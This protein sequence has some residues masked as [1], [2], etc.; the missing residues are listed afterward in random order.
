MRIGELSRRVGVS[1]DTLRV[2][3]RRYGLLRP[4]RSPGNA[5]LYSAVDEA[6]VRLMQRYINQRVPPA[7]AAQLSLAARF[8]LRGGR[9]AIP[10][11]DD[12]TL[13]SGQLRHA[14]D[15]FDEA[16][17]DQAL[18]RM[19]TEYSTPVVM[20]S[21]LLPYLH[22]VGERWAAGRTT[23]AQEHFASNFVMFRLAALSRGW[24]RGLGPRA[25]LACAP[26]EQ[27][28]IGLMCFG[29]ALHQH[30]WRI[31]FLGAA[32]PIDMLHAAAIE[33]RPDLITVCTYLSGGLAP[34][35]EEL[36]ELAAEWHLA[37]AGPGAGAG[38]AARCRAQHLRED[39]V[40]AA[41]AVAVGAFAPTAS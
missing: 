40:S 41:A 17:A 9:R 33:L 21:V 39:P 24:D 6:R 4:R 16:G 8:R 19:L 11:E 15:S 5:R 27:H 2:W 32:T 20:R 28:I 12:V 23:V 26:D 1:T 35:V 34:Q 13:A 31:A 14:L 22:D 30:G 37:L 25:L 10:T 38:F 36:R 3:E 29:I 7:Q 18:E